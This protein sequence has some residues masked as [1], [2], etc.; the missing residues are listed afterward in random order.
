[1]LLDDAL[2]LTAGEFLSLIF[3][4]A[5]T[6]FVE[7]CYL[8]PEKGQPPYPHT[9]TQFRPLPVGEIADNPPAIAARNSQGYGVYFGVTVS[10]VAKQVEERTDPKTGKTFSVQPRRHEEDAV[11]ATVL[12]QDID[13]VA[14]EA[15]YA[16]LLRAP[17]PPS[18]VV[19]SG[20]GIHG[21]WL[22]NTPV[23][24]TPENRED[25][26][27]SMHGLCNLCGSDA[28]V[29]DLARIMRLPGTVNT[30]PKRNGAVCEVLDCIPVFYDYDVLGPELRRYAPRDVIRTTRH[31][32]MSAVD[33]SLPRYV[34]DFIEHG[35][36][37]GERNHRLYVCAAFYR[38]HGYTQMQAESDLGPVLVG[39]DFTHEEAMRT[40]SSAFRGAPSPALPSYMTSRMAMG[41]TR[42]R[43]RKDGQS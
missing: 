3:R 4:R 20:G 10:G 14:P 33:K 18:V 34:L 30:K 40:I 36:P 5:T 16:Q 39:S 26:K 15:G 17:V 35:A 23:E 13:D 43:A 31:I 19:T 32:P 41:D 28:K 24:L 38:D 22:M 2:T 9:V 6:G 11:L 25:F 27:R 21:Y 37:Q 7:V 42:K 8:A 29:R 12:W 1:M